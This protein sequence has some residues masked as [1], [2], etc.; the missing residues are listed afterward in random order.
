[1]LNPRPQQKRPPPLNQL[2]QK[3]MPHFLLPNHFSKSSS[4]VPRD[5]TCSRSFFTHKKVKTVIQ[6]L[7]KK[8]QT[9]TKTQHNTNSK[10]SSNSKSQ[11]P[12]STSSTVSDSTDAILL[13]ETAVTQSWC[14]HIKLITVKHNHGRQFRESRMLF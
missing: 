14:F 4:V 11:Y 8:D 9:L 1:M 5:W 12:I 13:D 10:D 6:N 7:T 2:I 3:W